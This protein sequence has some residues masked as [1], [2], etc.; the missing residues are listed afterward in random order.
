MMN[1]TDM[2]LMMWVHAVLLLS[3]FMTF[4]AALLGL[5]RTII[6]GRRIRIIQENGSKRER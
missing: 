5:I 4:A 2:Q 6:N 1:Q 3:S